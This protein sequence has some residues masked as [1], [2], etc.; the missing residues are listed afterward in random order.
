MTYVPYANPYLSEPLPFKDRRTGLKAAGVVLIVMGAVAGCFTLTLPMTLFMAPPQA[1]G[2]MQDWRGVAFAVAMYAAIA[3]GCVWAGIG[4]LTIRR[5]VRP[6]VLAVAW[7]W[8]LSGLAGA[9][10]WLI[11]GPGVGQFADA[12]SAQAAASA[13]SA[14]GTAA[15]T[16]RSAAVAVLAVMG[17]FWFLMFFAVPLTFILIYQG[18]NVRAT[19]DHFDRR[20]SWTD[21]C[22]VPVFGLSLYLAISAA[23]M[24]AVMAYA[25]LPAFG[26]L[27][28]GAPAILVSLAV[29]ASLLWLAWSVFHLRP[30]GWWGTLLAV[31]VLWSS[32]LWSGLRL[33][34]D[35]YYRRLHY[36]PEQIEMMHRMGFAGSPRA[37]AATAV[38]AALAVVYLLYVR[39]FFRAAK[40]E[41][42][43][44]AAPPAAA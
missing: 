13:R 7:G 41:A 6:F 42:R 17:I 4:S 29:F 36:P 22:P 28:T 27:L 31:L 21:S 1:R 44:V 15:P 34:W 39:R 16:P 30:M 35:A 25:T 23:G 19:L 3:G 2:A 10:Y 8:L 40:H 20:P 32:W 24:L 38:L 37:A 33:D 5:W 26:V 9:L 43:T 12:M 11:A 14:G 18:R